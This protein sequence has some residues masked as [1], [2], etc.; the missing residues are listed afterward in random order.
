M[1]KAP[2]FSI[3]VPCLNE[4]KYLPSL[5]HDLVNQSFQDFEV[6]IVDGKSEDN[7]VKEASNFKSNI[8]SF[9]IISSDL[10]NV[11]VQRNLGALQ[12]KGDYLLFNDADNRLPP[13]FLSTLRDQLSL[14][15]PDI[16]SVYMQ[17]KGL[18]FSHRF[19]IDSINFY[20]KLQQK[21]SSPYI[22]EAFFGFKT[23]IFQN[24]KGFNTNLSVS[25][26]T[27]IL[28]R[29]TLLGY[30]FKVFASPKY[31]FSLRRLEKE[32]VIKMI[33]NIFKIEFLRFLGH[34]LT[35]NEAQK[36]Y[37][38]KGGKYYDQK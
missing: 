12:A 9:T 27:D 18:S 15:N 14:S 23:K 22:V 26:G 34:N 1:V 7:T 38:M 29:A 24:L 4:E 5:L 37:P 3:I 25:E 20:T 21:S 36:I 17:T 33:F 10:R 8:P 31:S 32:G 28:K 6:V 19:S 2:L 30:T 11:S 16:F 13:S 35:R